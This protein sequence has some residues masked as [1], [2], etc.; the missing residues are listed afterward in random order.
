M[1]RDAHFNPPPP[2]CHD[3]PN[4]RTLRYPN[5]FIQ[6]LARPGNRLES[7]SVKNSYTGEMCRNLSGA[8]VQGH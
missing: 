1:W 2:P 7:L 3:P 4:S 8:C 5:R 6:S